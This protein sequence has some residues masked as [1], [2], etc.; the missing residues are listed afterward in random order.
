MFVAQHLYDVDFM[1]AHKFINED[2]VKFAECDHHAWD[3]GFL[4]HVCDMNPNY[5]Y[6]IPKK[7]TNNITFLDSSHLKKNKSVSQKK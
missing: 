6:M 3:S 2:L 4:I 5:F 1:E 7:L